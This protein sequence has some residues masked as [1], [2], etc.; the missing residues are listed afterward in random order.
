MKKVNKSKLSLNKEIIISL[1]EREML[2]I[3]GGEILTDTQI[4]NCN[5]MTDCMGK[6][7][8]PHCPSNGC[9]LYT[10]GCQDPIPVSKYCTGNGCISERGTCVTCDANCAVKYS[11]INNDCF[12]PVESLINC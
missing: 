2:S 11:M 4:A 12:K 9:V 7:Q 1:S 3:N 6:T 8:A 10:D 5:T